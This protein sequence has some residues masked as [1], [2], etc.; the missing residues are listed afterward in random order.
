MFVLPTFAEGL[1]RVLLEAMAEGL[2]CLSSP[3]CGIPEI[4]E[5][6]F[7]YEFSDS[8]GFANGIIKLITDKDLM[9][10]QSARNIAI[11][12]K[13]SS[14]ILNEKRKSF[15]NKLKMLTANYFK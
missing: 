10:E 11:A 7:L 13:Y 4:L 5:K 12:K 2:P 1:P 8:H 14:K 15:Y 9:E 6:D 3:T